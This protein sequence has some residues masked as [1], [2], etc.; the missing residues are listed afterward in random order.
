MFKSKSVCELKMNFVGK[1]VKV[2]PVQTSYVMNTIYMEYI[3]YSSSS[4][5]FS[6]GKR[7]SL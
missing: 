5:L 7:Q 4:S 1:V 6:L 2:T 3:R